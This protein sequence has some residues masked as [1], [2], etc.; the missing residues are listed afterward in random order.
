MTKSFEEFEVYQKGIQLAKLIFKLLENKSFDKEY[1]F[2]DQIKRAVISIT[3]NIA[4]GS[5]YNNNKQLIR[6]LKISKGSCAEVRSMLV[7]ARE[8]ELISQL[9][10]EISY[11][12]SIEIS[13]NLSNFIKYL[14]TK[15]KE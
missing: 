9:E 7:L 8:L 3:N 6:Y 10:I 13:Q 1:S 5:E 11:N 12:L 2:K 4:E 14:N 15:I